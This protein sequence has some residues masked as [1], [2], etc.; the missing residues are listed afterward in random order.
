[1]GWRSISAIRRSRGCYEH[2]TVFS[3]CFE[4]GPVGTIRETFGLGG[5]VTVIPLNGMHIV[6][7]FPDT[8]VRTVWSYYSM[9]SERSSRFHPFSTSPGWR[10]PYDVLWKERFGRLPIF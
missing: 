6:C 3:L 2:Y 8:V 4:S 10:L 5:N 1:M 7:M 9:E